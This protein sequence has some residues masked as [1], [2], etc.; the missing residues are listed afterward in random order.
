[1]KNCESNERTVVLLKTQ[2]V[3]TAFDIKSDCHCW[4]KDV[5]TDPAFQVLNGLIPNRF[6]TGRSLGQR[7]GMMEGQLCHQVRGKTT[8]DG[9]GK[10]N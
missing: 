2:L 5:T 4:T 8:Y 7:L 10:L 9:L 6:P 3:T 1:M